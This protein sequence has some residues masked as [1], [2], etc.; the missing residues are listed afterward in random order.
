MSE[1]ERQRVLWGV[2][3]NSNWTEVIRASDY[4]HLRLQ[5]GGMQM[6]LDEMQQRLAEAK[7]L[8]RDLSKYQS[9]AKGWQDRV[10]SFLGGELE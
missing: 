9:N 4:D 10:D 6:V 2:H 3:P 8:L 5:C 1:I 7:S